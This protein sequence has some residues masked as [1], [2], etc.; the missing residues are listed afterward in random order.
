MIF[1]NM[2]KFIFKTILFLTITVFMYIIF[3]FKTTTLYAI[4]S[5]HFNY[6]PNY[7]EVNNLNTKSPVKVHMIANK[8][9]G[10]S[11]ILESDN[12]FAVV[13]SGEDEDYTPGILGVTGPG[14]GVEDR[15]ISY[16]KRIGI[17]KDNFIYYIGTH[18]HSDHIGSGDEVLNAIPAKEVIITE[19]SD[20]MI[21]NSR[22]H[23]DNQI[24]YNN[25]IDA[26]KKCNAKI[27]TQF[28]SD[29]I[30]LRLGS[31]TLTIYNTFS[32]HHNRT[33]DDANSM[34][35]VVKLK[36][37]NGRTAVIGGDFD[38]FLHGESDYAHR[39]GK[40]DVASLNHHGYWGSNT[41][42]WIS[43]L[44]AK[45]LLCPNKFSYS[46]L[47]K[48]PF[49]K[50]EEICSFNSI[51]KQL[52]KGTRI[53]SAGD[54]SDAGLDAVVIA[55]DNE[56]TNNIPNNFKHNFV[57]VYS[58]GN[59][60]EKIISLV[61]GGMIA[62]SGS[63]QGERWRFS[64]GKW[65]YL[66]SD[67]LKQ[68]GWIKY[69]GAWYYLSE[70]GAMKI[71]WVKTASK[72]YYFGENGAMRIGWIK[73]GSAWYYMSIS[74]DMRTGWVKDGDDWYFMN[75]NGSMRTGW[76]K[77]GG[78]WYYLNSDGSMRTDDLSEGN[79]IYRFNENGSMLAS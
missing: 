50:D 13:D 41:Q 68:T 65:Y 60:Y 7:V 48:D 53:F 11:F 3:N 12:E 54:G 63:Y 34:S 15:V 43:I 55:L 56:L 20:S 52:Y 39:I 36:A 70:D 32:T 14:Y 25:L 37:S 23:W 38:D 27:T 9:S 40:V 72:W 69:G 62:G 33:F 75:S 29:P 5:K 30:T 2:T 79:K 57:G 6:G 31:S 1:K 58:N 42:E 17:T 61:S 74:G 73:S 64:S 10:N 78:A 22:R 59:Y 67:G 35:L 77:S 16:M 19:Y 71:G 76:I 44:D 66:N 4:D 18:A 46:S 49:Q 28:Q 21:S 47:N 51:K 8:T 24:V 45:I 26:A